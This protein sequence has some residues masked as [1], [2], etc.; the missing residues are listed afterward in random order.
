MWK[1]RYRWCW[2]DADPEAVLKDSQ[3]LWVP[4]NFPSTEHLDD[5]AEY[6]QNTTANLAERLER[7][8]TI[9]RMEV[10]HPYVVPP[11]G[12]APQLTLLTPGN[13]P[14]MPTNQCS[15]RELMSLHILMAAQQST[16]WQR[17]Q[18]SPG[19]GDTPLAWAP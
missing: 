7:H 4:V 14:S 18:W 13:R 19:E 9:E 1:A 17:Q 11:G 15:E 5:Y 2:K 12:T 6:V 10:I 8:L 16:G 3:K